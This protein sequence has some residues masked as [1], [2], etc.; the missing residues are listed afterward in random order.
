MFK[1]FRASMKITTNG[2]FFAPVLRLIAPEYFGWNRYL[3]SINAM[4]K[5]VDESI[6]S[7]KET[8]NPHDLR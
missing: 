4:H 1:M 6:K 2:V 5:L 3:K 8:F 7:H